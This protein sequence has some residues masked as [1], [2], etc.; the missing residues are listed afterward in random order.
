LLITREAPDEQEDHDEGQGTAQEG[1]GQ[2]RRSPAQSEERG[3]EDV[4]GAEK[5]SARAEGRD[6]EL[7]ESAAKRLAG[8]NPCPAAV[9]AAAGFSNR[10]R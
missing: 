1:E 7:Q 3:G 9:S 2:A 6:Q 4:G 5:T 10:A 8:R